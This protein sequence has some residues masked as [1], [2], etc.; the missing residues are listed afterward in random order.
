MLVIRGSVRREPADQWNIPLE[1]E[2]ILHAKF[3]GG[4]ADG[5]EKLIGSSTREWDRQGVVIRTDDGTHAY[6]EHSHIPDGVERP[7]NAV[8]RKHGFWPAVLV[9]TV[10]LKHQRARSREINE[11]KKSIRS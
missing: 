2:P 6:D 10:H 4:P 8:Q 5:Q 3:H 11:G 7:A 1:E 9:S